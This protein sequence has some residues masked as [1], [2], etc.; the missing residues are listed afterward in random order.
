LTPRVAI[1]ARK[2][3]D[4]GIGTYIRELVAALATRAG[5]PQVAALLDPADLGRT[6]WAP[7][8]A[9]EIAV[10]AGKYGVWEHLAIPRAARRA[11]AEL[12][13]APHYTLPLGW[14]GRAIVTIHDL[15][16]IRYPKFFPPGTSLYARAVAG[17]AARRA[18]LVLT[19]SSATR[20][21]VLEFL[22]VEPER[23]RVV[24]L[25]VAAGLARPD[26]A[27]VEAFRRGRGLPAVYLLYVGARKR[28]KNL[29]LLLEALA[30]MTAAERPALVLSGRPWGAK[31]DLAAEARRLGVADRVAF[32]GD[33]AD[34][35]EL[36]ALYGGAALYLQPS[37]FE[38]FGLPPL[39]AMACGT[40]VISSDGGSLPE[41]VGDAGV[42]LSPRQPERW[43][44]A[45]R[46]LLGDEG[47]RGELA[48]RGLA[49]ARSFTWEKVAE[50]TLAAYREALS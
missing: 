6:G 20:D 8:V 21:D 45:I 15:I 23:V 27:R 9:R 3:R 18:R 7:G 48:R 11:G 41:V 12:L 29:T 35:S 36:A 43:A 4:G 39:E 1:D 24:P 37:L 40:P 34:A 50:A 32:S 2:L 17:S 30:R 28:H 22:G 46:E 10:R 38:G 49:R 44:T 26:P 25:A 31:E 33:L 19:D 14:S 16:H 5:A 47:R 13:H 42:V